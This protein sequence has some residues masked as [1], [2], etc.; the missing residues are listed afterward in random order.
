[1]YTAIIF[2]NAEIR[3]RLTIRFYQQDD[4]DRIERLITLYRTDPNC[5][6]LRILR[7]VE[8]VMFLL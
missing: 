5:K 4:T 6:N 8:S 3:D 2:N 7:D 1:M